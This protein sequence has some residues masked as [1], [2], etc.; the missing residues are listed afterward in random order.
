MPRPL[1]IRLV[2]AVACAFIG[3]V[4]ANFGGPLVVMVM[5]P[6]MTP[7]DLD[8]PQQLVERVLAIQQAGTIGSA[9]SLVGLLAAGISFIYGFVVLAKWFVGPPENPSE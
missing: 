8:Q 4:V 5:V 3:M 2:V 6:A 7:A 9:V 1:R